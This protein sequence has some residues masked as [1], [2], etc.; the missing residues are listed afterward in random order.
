MSGNT[1]RLR[2]SEA[3]KKISEDVTTQDKRAFLEGFQSTNYQRPTQA[4]I[5]DYCKGE[6]GQNLDLAYDLLSFLKKRIKKREEALIELNRKKT[7]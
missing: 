5:N 6:I 7:K 2:F 1:Q 4:T 3:F